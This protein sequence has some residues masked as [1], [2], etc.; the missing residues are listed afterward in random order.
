MTVP[1][2]RDLASGWNIEVWRSQLTVVPSGPTYD[3]WKFLTTL[4][5]LHSTASFSAGQIRTR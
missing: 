4:S 5:V 3:D 2:E 1:I